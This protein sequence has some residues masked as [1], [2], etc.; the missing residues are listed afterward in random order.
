M[1][2]HCRNL[3]IFIGVMFISLPAL[4]YRSFYVYESED[5]VIKN[6]YDIVEGEVVGFFTPAMSFFR[7][8]CFSSL[9]RLKVSRSMK[10]KYKKDDIAIVGSKYNEKPEIKN[11]EHQIV[12]LRETNK[13]TYE[14]CVFDY[15][16]SFNKSDVFAIY[17][18]RSGLFRI[19]SD[20]HE[21][22]LFKS[23]ACTNRED[24]D[25]SKLIMY[26]EY[27]SQLGLPL[28]KEKRKNNFFARLNWPYQFCASLTAPYSELEQKFWG[29]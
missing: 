8:P 23:E 19:S 15:T 9:Y 24:Q 5:E 6:S 12:I 29:E 3:L 26:Q 28:V 22:K 2:K 14:D 25:L 10:G 11:G 1:Y 18:L 20:L 27:F 17:I 21:K 13:Y 7:K 16:E 4:S